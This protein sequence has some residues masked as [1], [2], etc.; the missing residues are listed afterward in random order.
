MNDV[1]YCLFTRL[2]TVGNALEVLRDTYTPMSDDWLMATE[3]LGLLD[4][5]IDLLVR[6]DGLD[7]VDEEEDD[8]D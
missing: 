7:G 2:C 3:V 5:S 1:G 8:H 4:E 6:S